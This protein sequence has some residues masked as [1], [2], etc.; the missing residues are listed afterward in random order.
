MKFKIII[1]SILFSNLLIS[2]SQESTFNNISVESL[3]QDLA[4]LKE[5][6]EAIHA[7]LYTYTPKSAMDSFFLQVE[8][9][10]TTP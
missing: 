2:Q 5:N 1:T 9:E 6:L 8:K 10:I 7:G 4:I 3:K